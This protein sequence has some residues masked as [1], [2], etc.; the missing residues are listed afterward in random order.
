MSEF[1]AIARYADGKHITIHCT[2]EMAK[3][4]A[5]KGTGPATVIEWFDEAAA[6]HHAGREWFKSW[7]DARWEPVHSP[8][9]WGASNDG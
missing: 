8:G 6:G 7:S 9:E 1:I 4:S 3:R 2:E 5:E